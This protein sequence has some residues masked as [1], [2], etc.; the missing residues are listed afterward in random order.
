MKK[1]L[2]AVIIELIVALSAYAYLMHKY[3][4]RIGSQQAQRILLAL[5][6]AIVISGIV[7]CIIYGYG[8]E[9]VT[10]YV[11][12]LIASFLS[13]SISL[14]YVLVEPRSEWRLI[15]IYGITYAILHLILSGIISFLLS[16]NKENFRQ[17]IGL[18]D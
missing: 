18:E 8:F 17:M 6:A 9:P 4:E 11:L 1:N 2:L 15:M 16:I 12:R 13:H 3:S 7:D 14:Y 5:A 10:A